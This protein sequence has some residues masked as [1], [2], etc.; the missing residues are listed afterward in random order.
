M[1][2]KFTRALVELE[3]KYARKKSDENNLTGLNEEEIDSMLQSSRSHSAPKQPPKKRN[4]VRNFIFAG[5][6]EANMASSSDEQEKS[7]KI[8]EVNVSA[9]NKKRKSSATDLKHLID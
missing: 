7:H 4:G 6:E 1:S 5:P 3:N 8:S 2:S 9:R